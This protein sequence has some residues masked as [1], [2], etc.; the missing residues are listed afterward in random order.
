M[1]FGH[2]RGK[3]IFAMT[4][5]LVLLVMVIG[6]A[7]ASGSTVVLG[8]I[9]NSDFST[10]VS[11]ASVSVN[12]NGNIQS[13]SSQ[14]DGSYAAH[15]SDSCDVGGSVSVSAIDSSSGLSG[16]G[17]ASVNTCS[18][19]C[20]GYTNVAVVNINVNPSGGNGPSGGHGS[21][22]NWTYEPIIWNNV[23]NNTNDAPVNV[24]QNETLSNDNA[25]VQNGTAQN[26]T[27]Q[28]S[29]G[30]TGGVIGA[31]GASWIIIV[32]FILGLLITYLV[33]RRRISQG[34][35]EDESSPNY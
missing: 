23:T 4:L 22:K 7:S 29:P 9:Y 26:S 16:S 31:L 17:S 32:V 5:G 18:S 34:I 3:M 15:F 25:G 14:N 21:S 28:N 11:G 10:G 20:D 6:F 13:T 27:T 2:A 30:I 1:Q 24:S 8:K 33:V 12:C 35:G 19:D